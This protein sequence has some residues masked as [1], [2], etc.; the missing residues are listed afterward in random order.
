MK[1]HR[2]NIRL[3]F[4]LKLRQLRQQKNLSLTELSANTGL[5]ISYLNEIEKGKKYPKGD[6][7]IALASALDVDYDKL[8]SLKVNKSLEPVTQILNS[9]I[10]REI[11]L[12]L[13]GIER[14]KLVE[15]M[16]LAPAK[17][18]AFISTLIEIARKYDL[19]E[20]QFYFASLR[21]YQELHENYFEDLEKA[22]DDFVKEYKIDRS[23]LGNSEY[24]RQLLVSKF[25][26]QVDETEL[27]ERPEL[28]DIRSIFIEGAKKILI[29]NQ[30]AENQK[31]FLYGKEIGYQ[32]LQLK[33]RAVTTPWSKAKS[34]EQVLNNM[35]AS[36]FSGALLIPKSGLI[37][38]LEAFFALKKW[39]GDTFLK[40]MDKYNS[41]PEMFI[42]RLINICPKFFGLNNVFFLRFN[43]HKGEGTYDMTKEL[44]L[45]KLHNPHANAMLEHYCRRWI[46]LTIFDE[47]DDLE[48]EGKYDGPIIRA[49]RSNYINSKNEYFCIS[50]AR[51]SKRNPDFRLSVTL[52]FLINNDFKKKVQFWDDG[53]VL[54]REV[55]QSCER[56]PLENCAERISPPLV[57]NKKLKV[58]KMEKAM[59]ELMEQ[60]KE[61][62]KA[63]VS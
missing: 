50:F 54:T 5:S 35:K 23:Q 52:G 62:A 49:Q 59:T 12:E 42:Y 10:L 29:N 43:H 17:V 58:E 18:N 32:F 61:L 3:I 4:G 31:A 21:S 16:S 26:Y 24:L 1:I 48:K 15:I 25:S 11:P 20:E 2:E 39:D 36:Y 30:M 45:S 14:S 46:S 19:N 40:M 44:H 55:N 6:K 37:K 56:C 63:T 38:D 7:I 34:F 47:I 28:S 60:E 57:L 33:E 51:K 27:T 13:F 53:K 22:V 9:P 41:S 8:V